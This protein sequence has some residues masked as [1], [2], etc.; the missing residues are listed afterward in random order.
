MVR[1]SVVLFLGK[2]VQSRLLIG[3]F[4]LGA[5]NRFGCHLGC[6]WEQILSLDFPYSCFGYL[7]IFGGLFY[8]NEVEAF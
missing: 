4:R 6:S 3:R 8:A 7:H 1:L 5:L 2:H